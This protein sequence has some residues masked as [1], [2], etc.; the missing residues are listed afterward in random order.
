MFREKKMKMAIIGGAGLLGSTTAFYAGQ[1]DLLDEIKLIDLNEKMLM[2]HVMDMGQALSFITHTRITA[3]SYS[4]IDDCDIILLT[5][6]LPE[7]NVKNRNEYLNG[8]LSIVKGTCEQILAGSSSEKIF[9]CASN[10]VD[11][12]TYIAYRITGWSPNKIIGFSVNDTIRMRWALSRVLSKDIDDIDAYCIGE[13]GDGQLPLLDQAKSKDGTPLSINNDQRE[14]AQIMIK[15]WFSDY[16]ALNSGRTSGWT[17]AVGIVTVIKAILTNSD[18]IIPCSA[19]LN[20]EYGQELL[21]IGVPCRLCTSGIKEIVEIKLT[22]E[23]QVHFSKSSDKIRSLIK[24]V[25][26]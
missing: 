12:F 17:S 8:N 19:V 23:Q 25:G 15:N 22:P 9:I 18:K 1:L 16:Q 10:P 6:S 14:Q 13:H 7:H 2:S 5:A 11:V 4:D 3:A 20:G 21:S 26:F 24:S